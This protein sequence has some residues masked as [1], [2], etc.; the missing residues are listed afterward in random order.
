[1]IEY[2][3][4]DRSEISYYVS[5]VNT[6]GFSDIDLEDFFLRIF[7]HLRIAKIV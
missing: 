2:L 4:L 3:R 6:F 5:A 1:M 7:R